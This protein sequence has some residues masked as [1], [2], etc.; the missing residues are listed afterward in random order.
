MTLH[1]EI[2]L[3][4]DPKVRK[5]FDH[6]YLQN[7]G[8]GIFVGREEYISKASRDLEMPKDQVRKI[9]NFLEDSGLIEGYLGKSKH[10]QEMF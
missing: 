6:F 9:V 1:R 3:E 8:K 4:N 10:G 7:F 2:I 5:V